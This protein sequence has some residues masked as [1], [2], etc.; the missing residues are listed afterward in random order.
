M[1][2]KAATHD[3]PA[4]GGTAGY[5]GRM[6]RDHHLGFTV[7]GASDVPSRFVTGFAAKVVAFGRSDAFRDG[8][9]GY[10]AANNPQ[11]LAGVL[12][13][14]LQGCL[15]VGRQVGQGGSGQTTA[16]HG[17]GTLHAC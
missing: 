2:H 3:V 1:I 15:P 14:L 7:R 10:R 4:I 8:C 17:S 9:R 13:R 6:I 16:S 12:A 11:V 5:I